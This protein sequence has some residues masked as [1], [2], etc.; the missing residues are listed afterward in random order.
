MA[1]QEPTSIAQ[2]A[3]EAYDYFVTDTRPRSDETFT[4]T[5]DDAPEWVT[6]LVRSAHGDFLPDDWRYESIRSALGFIADNEVDGD[7]L[8][9]L[10]SEWS[11]QNVDTYTGQ[12]L[13]WLSSN[14]NRAG[15]CD[16]AAAEF[17]FDSS[18][19][20]AQWIGMGQYMESGEVWA[21]VVNT[22]RERLEELQS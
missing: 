14:L 19:G 7:E 22:L 17:G 4:K 2:L 1:T 3:Q 11:D 5:R 18:E 9:D 15:Y 20:I 13:A 21:S 6:D 16:D 8:D 12:R 10:A